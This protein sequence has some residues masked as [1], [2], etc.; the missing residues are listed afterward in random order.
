MSYSLRGVIHEIGETQQVTESFKKRDI[1]VVVSENPQFPEYVSLQT[2]QERVHIFDNLK[3]GEY[4]EVDW[5]LRGRP[6]VNKEGITTYFNSLVAW[7]VT[8][9]TNTQQAKQP[10]YTDIP[11]VDISE[12]DDN[13]DLPF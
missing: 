10:D 1:V 3:A 6:W 11:P 13:D 4:V 12:G 2:T 9:L 5:N 7:R 8:P